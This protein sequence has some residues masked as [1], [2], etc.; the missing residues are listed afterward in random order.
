MRPSEL[1]FD[2][3]GALLDVE[4]GVLAEG[5]ELATEGLVLGAGGDLLGEHLFDAR[6][7]A[8]DLLVE[9]RAGTLG[10]ERDRL[11]LTLG[12]GIERIWH[13]VHLSRSYGREGRNR[14]EMA[15]FG[16]DQ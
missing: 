5:V 15:P 6:A 10:G 7:D 9:L 13:G 8:L 14:G 1:A 16:P 2:P 11:G 4:A 12:R 3:F